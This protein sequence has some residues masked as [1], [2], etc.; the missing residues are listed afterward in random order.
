MTEGVRQEKEN[1]DWYLS[2]P[3]F[4]MQTAKIDR[5]RINFCTCNKRTRLVLLTYGP[6]AS[7]IKYIYISFIRYY[8]EGGPFLH[9]L[10][11]YGLYCYFQGGKHTHSAHVHV[12]KPTGTTV[13]LNRVL[14]VKCTNDCKFVIVLNNHKR[15]IF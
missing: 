4:A 1:S 15:S 3:N 2:G 10:K 12:T 11:G 6:H 14:F 8:D 7:S 9:P 5:S 13:Y